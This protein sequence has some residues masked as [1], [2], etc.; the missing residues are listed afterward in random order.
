M[1]Q[2]YCKNPILCTCDDV[3]KPNGEYNPFEGGKPNDRRYR[4]KK[5]PQYRK[6]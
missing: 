4:N 3:M 6:T 5:H 2:S 1:I